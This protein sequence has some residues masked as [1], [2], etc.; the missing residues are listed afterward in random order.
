M[1]RKMIYAAGIGYLFRRFIG[2]GRSTSTMGTGGSRW[3]SRR[4]W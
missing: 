2:G 3:G 1:L 4:G